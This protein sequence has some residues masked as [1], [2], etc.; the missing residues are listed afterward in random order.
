MLGMIKISFVSFDIKLLRTLYTTFMR[1]LIE[2]AV[3]VWSPY[4]K[5]DIDALE[6]VQHR[7]TRVIPSLKKLPYEERIV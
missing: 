7:V 1:S 3:S 2:Y 6:R 4:L 5:G